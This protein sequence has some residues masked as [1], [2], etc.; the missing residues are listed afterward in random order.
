V[1][2]VQGPM[3]RKNSNAQKGGNAH[4]RN[5]RAWMKGKKRRGKDGRPTPDNAPLTPGDMHS[6]TRL[7]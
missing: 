2:Y 7:R 1:G 6:Q 4:A 3:P 5:G